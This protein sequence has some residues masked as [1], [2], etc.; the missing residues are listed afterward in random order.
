MQEARLRA[1]GDDEKHVAKRLAIATAEEVKGRALADAV[2]V[3]DDLD[4]AV[5]EVAGILA[6]RRSGR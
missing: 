3:N 4:R 5:A 2:V 1:R 6:S